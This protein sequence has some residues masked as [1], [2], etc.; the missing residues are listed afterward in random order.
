MSPFIKRFRGT[1]WI[2]DLEGR[3]LRE[4]ENAITK[5]GLRI[6][7]VLMSY[8]IASLSM[9]KKIQKL[10]GIARVSMNFIHDYV[11]LW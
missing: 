1:A 5:S 3:I 10:N 4:I 11:A 2:F 9:D 6:V 7:V 8:S